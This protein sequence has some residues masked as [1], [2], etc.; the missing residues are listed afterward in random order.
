M[1]LAPYLYEENGYTSK[2]L[3]DF[4]LSF[5]YKFY[6]TKNFKEITNI[7]DFVKNIEDGASVNIFLK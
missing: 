2:Q 5:K 6:N 3:L 4:I 1:E 7:F